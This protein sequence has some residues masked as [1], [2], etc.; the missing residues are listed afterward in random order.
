VFSP[1]RRRG[2]I[3]ILPAEGFSLHLNILIRTLFLLDTAFG[4]RPGNPEA[5]VGQ[6]SV[7]DK[8]L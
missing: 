2:S 3:S 5:D 6:R 4:Q 1:T 7:R 8:D